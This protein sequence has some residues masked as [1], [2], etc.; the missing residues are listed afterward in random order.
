MNW[1]QLNTFQAV[2][3]TGG[4]TKASRKLNLSQPAVSQQ[5][6]ALE[7]SL[8]VKL[9]DRSGKKIHLT[10]EGELLLS[11]TSK[12]TGELQEIKFLFDELLNLER[13]R[14]DIGSSA[15]FGTYLLPKVIGKFHNTYPGI[16]IDLHAGNSHNVISMLLN[17]EIEFGFGGLFEDEP[18][19]NYTL[20]H[21]E[22][23]I[24]VVANQHPLASQ[25]HV[26]IDSLKS[27][28]LILR[29][30]GTRIRRDMET[31]FNH[32][33][34]AFFPER[35]IELENVEIAKKMIEEGI[36]LTILPRAAV[37]SELNLG[38][39]KTIDLPNLNL[40]AYYYLY[41]PKHRSLSQAAKVFLRLMKKTIALSDSFDLDEVVK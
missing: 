40:Y 41:Y 31:W 9:F 1:D 4:F 30:K 15:V 39:L 22:P 7:A 26:T 19:V 6:Q 37:E 8:H 17:G 16:E 24:A 27:V 13:G 29:E 33:D 12:I 20:V 11:R 14:L 10:K 23:L 38:L 2:A 35:F 32:A 25:D 34:N 3:E 28:P 21:Q 18:K 36:G 5:I